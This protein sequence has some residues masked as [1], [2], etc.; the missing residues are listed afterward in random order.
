MDPRMDPDGPL[1]LEK[2]E[3]KEKGWE[4][5]KKGSSPRAWGVRRGWCGIRV[6]STGDGPMKPENH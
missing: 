6:C 1:K 4:E 2:K 3:G 5:E